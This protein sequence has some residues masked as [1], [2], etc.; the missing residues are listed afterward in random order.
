MAKH[1][2]NCECGG[3]ADVVLACGDTT[4]VTECAC[5]RMLFWAGPAEAEP[6]SFAISDTAS[7]GDHFGG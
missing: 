2:V 3:G 1:Y 7:A 4:A 6:L 5:G